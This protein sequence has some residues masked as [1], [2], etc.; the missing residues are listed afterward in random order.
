MAGYAFKDTVKL[1]VAAKAGFQRGFQHRQTLAG[2]INPKKSFHAL[3]VSKIHQ[4]NSRLLL[5]QAAQTVWTQS[6]TPGKFSQCWGNAFITD[7]ARGFFHGR[8]HVTH[9]HVS[10]LLEL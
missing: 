5:E 6:R 10:G 7:E 2:A 4:R 1:R 9:R 8:M 3:P